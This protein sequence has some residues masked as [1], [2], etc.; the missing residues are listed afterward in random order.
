MAQQEIKDLKKKAT[1]KFIKRTAFVL[2]GFFIITLCSALAFVWTFDAL[3]FKI[4]M[5]GIVICIMLSIVYAFMNFLY[6]E[7]WSITC[8]AYHSTKTIEDKELRKSKFK[9][10][11]EQIAKE[12]GYELPKDSI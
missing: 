4:L 2:M 10:R 1:P 7:A 11:L 5:T 3:Y 6:N 8:E 12:R 9:E